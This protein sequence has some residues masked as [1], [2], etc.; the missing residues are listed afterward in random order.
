MDVQTACK[1]LE[2]N[3]NCTDE[4]LKKAYRKAAFK[5]H[6]DTGGSHDEFLEV[7]EAYT[8]L[9]NRNSR[10]PPEPPLQNKKNTVEDIRI[11]IAREYISKSHGKL[12][13]SNPYP[14]MDSV[15]LILMRLVFRRKKI[16]QAFNSIFQEDVSLP[17]AIF[18]SY[19]P[20]LLPLENPEHEVTKAYFRLIDMVSNTGYSTFT[21]P[22]CVIMNRLIPEY[23]IGKIIRHLPILQDALDEI[24]KLVGF[25]TIINI[26]PETLELAEVKTHIDVIVTYLHETVPEIRRYF[27]VKRL[28]YFLIS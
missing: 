9:L 21:I 4:Q 18:L 24:P 8:I 3:A 19:I 20:D 22:F 11:K 2:I 26:Y 15:L 17:I 13:L 25:G 27:E 5:S 10:G 12:P 1:I 14:D 6:P 23:S 7:T 28:M 16:A